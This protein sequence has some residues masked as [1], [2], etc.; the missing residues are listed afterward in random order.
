[1]LLTKGLSGRRPGRS[2]GQVHGEQGAGAA[3]VDEHQVVVVPEI[4][5][6]QQ[7]HHAGKG[8]A[9]VDR[10]QQDALSPG[11]L[12]D[13]GGVLRIGH[14][15]AGP[16]VGDHLE[17]VLLPPEGPLQ[18]PGGLLSQAGDDLVKGVGV[19]GDAGDLHPRQEPLGAQQQSGSMCAILGLTPQQVEEGCAQVEGYVVPVNYNSPVQTVI[20]GETAAV[21]A[22]IAKFTEMGARRCVKLAVSA[23]FHSKLMQPAADAFYEKI[24]DVKFSMPQK[25]FYCNLTGQLL[26]DVSDMPGYLAKHIVSPVRFTTELDNMQQAG[27]DTFVECGPGKVLTG[28]VKKTLSGVNAINVACARERGIPVV[29]TPTSNSNAVAELAISLM[30]AAARKLKGNDRML[31]R[32]AER[33]VP[34]SLSGLELTGK[35]LGLVGYGHIGSCVARIAVPLTEETRGLIGAAELAACRKNA[36]LVNTARGGVVDEAALYTALV[37]GKLFAAASDVFVDE[38]AQPDNPLLSLE[39]FIGTLHMGASTEEALLRV[40]R[41]V[42]EDVIAVLQGRE[43]RYLYKGPAPADF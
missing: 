2:A 30:L 18:Q 3:G 28:L 36:I 43:P 7:L 13:I 29:F 32:G 24:K 41:D 10:V 40:G 6:P 23:A 17:V 26:T 37:E 27:Y 38:P 39:N 16:N 5:L 8:L 12:L 1:M 4:A 15:V 9:G 42:A 11:Q 19:H 35:T 34:P 14:R 22:A 21:D 20:A 33:I 25:E 31:M